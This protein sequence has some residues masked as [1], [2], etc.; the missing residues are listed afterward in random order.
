[1]KT[2]A[3]LTVLESEAPLGSFRPPYCGSDKTVKFHSKKLDYSLLA[4]LKPVPGVSPLSTVE[5]YF[6]RP[7]LDHVPLWMAGAQHPTD[8]MPNYGREIG[9]QVGNDVLEPTF[10]MLTCQMEASPG[11]RVN[12]IQNRFRLG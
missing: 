5:R 10:K 4:R 2:A 6:E 9:T 1:M 11:F 7:W 12:Q 3:I 8:N